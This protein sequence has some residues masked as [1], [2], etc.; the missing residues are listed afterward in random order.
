MLV[1]ENFKDMWCRNK[2]EI[3]NSSSPV[4]DDAMVLDDPATTAALREPPVVERRMA[5]EA[6]EEKKVMGTTRF[7]TLSTKDKRMPIFAFQR[8]GI[9]A[10]KPKGRHNKKKGTQKN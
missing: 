3:G 10:H 8:H 1:K 6:K 7:K 2:R 5:E 4:Q 9:G